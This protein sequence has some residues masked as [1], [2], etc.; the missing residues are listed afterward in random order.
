MIQ[1]VFILLILLGLFRPKSNIVAVSIFLLAIILWGWNYDNPDIQNYIWRYEESFD[2]YTGEFGFHLLCKIGNY[3]NLSFQQF[4]IVIGII[5]YSFLYYIIRN[6][7]IYVAFVS[8]IYLICFFILDVTQMRNFIA[9]I[10]IFYAISKY[11]KPEP[12]SWQI[13]KYCILVIC[14][15][16]IHLTSVFFLLFLLVYIKVDW[17]LITILIFG[18]ILIESSIYIFIYN[19]VGKILLYDESEISLLASVC[20]S[21]MQIVNYYFIK[22]FCNK[23]LQ[24]NDRREIIISMNMI[25]IS[26]IPFYWDNAI[27]S[28][29][30]RFVA[31]MNITFIADGFFSSKSVKNK[32][33]F[34]CYA[35]YFLIMFIGLDLDSEVVSCVFNKNK[36]LN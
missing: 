12:T 4:K 5:A 19:N 24:N 18:A 14:A 11:L 30:L 13:I 32:L 23:Y 10:I 8:S 22:M 21:I 31:I 1:I 15:T 6:N 28:R 3:L 36:L 9:F 17:K 2:D 20:Y 27:F 16:T 7:T 25:L 34:I 26:I 29:L 33:L 35:C